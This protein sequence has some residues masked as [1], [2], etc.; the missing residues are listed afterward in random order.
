MLIEL[1]DCT[2]EFVRDYSDAPGGTNVIFRREP[3]GIL[4]LTE[5]SVFFFHHNSLRYLF[6]AKEIQKNP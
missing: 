6:F 5:D 2:P 4:F 3:K 1:Q